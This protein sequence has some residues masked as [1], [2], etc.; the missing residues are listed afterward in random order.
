MIHKEVVSVEWLRNNL[1][2]K[3]LIILDASPKK[4]V[5]GKVSTVEDLG[6][7]NARIFDIK[8]KFSNQESAFPNTVPSAFQFEQAC[9]ELGIN[10]DSKIVVYDNLGIYTSPR[11]WWLFK[12]MGHEDICVLNGGLPEWVKAGIETVKKSD[13]VQIFSKGNFKSKIKEAVIIEYR[14]V[15]EN[16]NSKNFQIID[17][18]SKGRFNGTA[19]E[20]RKHL[21]SGNIPHSINIPF[22]SLL[23]NG[24]FKSIEELE[25]IF[26]QNAS[27]KDRLVFSCGSG[28]TA[29]IV[30][31]ASEIA[32]KRSRYLYDGSWTEYA[33]LQKLTKQVD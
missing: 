20:P 23:E 19:D 8:G 27:K 5:S 29:C 9:Q 1:S 31:L 26:A 28:I 2:N 24:K 33:E 22:Q 13:L 7:P 14:T 17:A 16:I 15:V 12:T 6:I 25:K 18:R 30:M 4:T 21:K 32:F 10:N 11:V 3:N